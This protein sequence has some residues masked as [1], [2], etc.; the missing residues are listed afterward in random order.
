MFTVDGTKWP[1]I[2]LGGEDVFLL[3]LKGP[4]GMNKLS[5]KNERGLKKNPG[6]NATKPGNSLPCPL[7]IKHESLPFLL[8]P[9]FF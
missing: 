2:L 7:H 3:I 5:K 6:W 4:L 8:D 9:H 1:S